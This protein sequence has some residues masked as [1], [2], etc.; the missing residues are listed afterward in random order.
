MAA[1]LAISLIT[2]FLILNVLSGSLLCRI[3]ISPA[4]EA[5]FLHHFTL[6]QHSVMEKAHDSRFI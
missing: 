3:H 2:V 6:Q 1:R 4:G 5:S